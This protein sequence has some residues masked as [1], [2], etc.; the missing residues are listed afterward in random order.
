MD[1]DLEIIDIINMLNNIIPKTEKVFLIDKNTYSIITEIKNVMT[2]GG[3]PITPF[4]NMKLIEPLYNQFDGTP[5]ITEM[6]INDN[7]LTTEDNLNIV[8]VELIISY[9][10]GH[11]NSDINPSEFTYDPNLGIELKIGRPELINLDIVDLL[12]YLSDKYQVIIPLD[13]SD[14]ILTILDSLSTDVV[15]RINKPIDTVYN[16]YI[17]NLGRLIVYKEGSIKELRYDE[18]VLNK[19]LKGNI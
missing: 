9:L 11:L 16:S 2:A 4:P 10:Y 19:K 5:I 12:S 7:N 13:F 18:L 3:F 1:L 6:E 17:N 14:R 15:S 8:T